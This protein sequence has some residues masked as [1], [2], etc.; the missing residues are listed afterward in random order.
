MSAGRRWTRNELLMAMNLYCRL[1]FGRLHARNAEIIQLAAAMGRSSSSLAMKL[2]NFASLDPVQQARGISGLSGASNADRRIWDEFHA[3]WEGA[4]TESQALLQTLTGSTTSDN[5][6][7]EDEVDASYLGR[8]TET[9]REVAVR[10]AQWFFRKAV[11]ASYAGKCCISGITC[12]PL[13][14]ASHIVP[15]T[16]H[17]AHRLNPRNGLCLSRLHDAAFDRGLITFDAELR[18]VISQELR[19]HL[20]NETIKTAFRRYERQPLQL[21]NR[22]QPDASFLQHHREVI[23]R[24]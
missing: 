5:S 16:A 6:D 1:P 19:E 13:L 8:V 18:L 14:V 12:R 7:A 22:F 9:R 20:G 23:F 17:P 21:P 24:G 10:T 4:V 11:L 2:V 15:W 3:N